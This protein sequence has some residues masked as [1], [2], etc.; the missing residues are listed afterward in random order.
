MP[1]NYTELK[2]LYTREYNKIHDKEKQVFHNVI[3]QI[4]RRKI[5]TG[6][7][8]EELLF[9]L[10]GSVDDPLAPAKK[11]NRHQKM[12]REEKERIDA[13]TP[14]ERAELA[15]KAKEFRAS[16]LKEIKERKRDVPGALS[17]AET[18]LGY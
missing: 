17:S 18:D 5:R 8:P 15:R 13:M 16:R 1:E 11:E 7:L 12:I 4:M 2:K 3:V 10:D 6:H 14:E 9:I